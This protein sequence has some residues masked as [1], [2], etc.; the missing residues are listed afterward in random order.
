MNHTTIRTFLCASALAS[1]LGSAHAHNLW[2]APDTDGSYLVQFGGHQGRLESY[3]A[4]KLQS[5]TAYSRHGSQIKVTSQVGAN[6]VK[7][8][9]QREAAMLVAEFDNGFFSKAPGAEMLAKPMNANPGALEGVHARK[10]HKTILRWGH[11]ARMTLGQPFEI[12]A[13]DGGHPHAGE[14]LKVQVL[15]A[16]KPTAGARVSIGE[17]GPAVTTGA[18]GIAVVIPQAGSNHL[19]GALRL[20]LTGDPRA[21]TLSYEY[22]FAFDVH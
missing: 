10:F 13:V 1:L 22:L 4:D 19:L 20:P 9:P 8:T 16:G 17:A 14:P 7:V 3:A 2:L 18:D 11:V 15:L 5:V 12:R 6:G 21:T